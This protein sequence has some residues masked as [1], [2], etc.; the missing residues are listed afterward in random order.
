MKSV[1]P[2]CLV[3]GVVAVWAVTQTGP[4]VQELTA[5]GAPGAPE[6]AVLEGEGGVSRAVWETPVGRLDPKLVRAER[7]KL[8]TQL[9]YEQGT[10]ELIEQEGSSRTMTMLKRKG[11]DKQLGLFFDSRRSLQLVDGAQMPEVG[12]VVSDPPRYN[13]EESLA[14][15]RGQLAAVL[16]EGYGLADERIE[17]AMRSKGNAYIASYQ[18]LLHGYPYIDRIA[19]LHVRAT[20]DG[21]VAGFAPSVLLTSASAVTPKLSKLEALNK[22]T[23]DVLAPKGARKDAR[24]GWYE[25]GS[26]EMRLVWLVGY[27]DSEEFH[28]WLS[29][30]LLDGPD[31]ATV[32]AET[33]AV[34]GRGGP[35]PY[36]AQILSGKRL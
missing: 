28:R 1:L 30:V 12:G 23:A 26:G 16:P 18:I 24:L 29:D 10:F 14:R 22:V 17:E 3:L 13:R 31:H 2:V 9:G 19:T 5:I 7:E 15:L 32:D 36:L 35:S 20:Q 8:L 25:S 21:V 33:G 27:S 34:E 11:S 6:D 4:R